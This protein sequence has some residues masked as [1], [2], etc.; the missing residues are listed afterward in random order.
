MAAAAATKRIAAVITASSNA[1]AACVQRLIELAPAG[2]EVRAVFR[3]EAKAASLAGTPRDNVSVVTG[4]DAS[5]PESLVAA[6]TG[7]ETAV[8][9]TPHDA[10][11]GMA[12]DAALTAAMVNAAI[13]QGVKH[14]IYV[15]SWTVGAQDDLPALATRFAP[16][17]ALLRERAEAGAV[18]WTFLRSGFFFSNFAGMFGSLKAGDKLRFPAVAIPP[19]DP[20]AMGHVAAAIIAD[21]GT[22]HYGKVY[23]VS[24]P[25]L[26]TTAEM[27][28]V[29]ADALGRPITHE[30][31]SVDEFC[32]PLPP[33]LQELVAYLSAKQA[34]AIPL[35]ADV[36]AVTGSKPKSLREW[37][38]E[39]PGLFAHE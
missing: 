12:D 3:T 15:G 4:P 19:M 25:E 5:A 17:E 30:D 23:D 34:D 24:G 37:V 38:G 28:A 13:D 26:L 7:A 27:A 11:R 9:V 20:S 21:G 31:V 14:I 18:Q 8:I 16:T 29:F 33:F 6:F 2:V 10:S 1:G 36:E 32:A 35:S 39:N 22:K